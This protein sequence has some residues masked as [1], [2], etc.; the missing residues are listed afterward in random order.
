MNNCLYDFVNKNNHLDTFLSKVIIN[1]IIEYMCDTSKN[2]KDFENTLQKAYKKQFD[3]DKNKTRTKIQMYVFDCVNII[4]DENKIH[5]DDNLL[6]NKNNN[7]INKITLSFLNFYNSI[8]PLM[9]KHAYPYQYI[10]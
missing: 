8:Q 2:I 5:Y 6:Y 7:T 4:I 9:N 10:K 1:I 3:N